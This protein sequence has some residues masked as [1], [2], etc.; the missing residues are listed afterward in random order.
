[1]LPIDVDDFEAVLDDGHILIGGIS[2]KPFEAN[3]VPAGEDHT[4]CLGKGFKEGFIARL[5]L[6]GGES[7]GPCELTSTSANV[8]AAV[9]VVCDEAQAARAKRKGKS[10]DDAPVIGIAAMD[11]CEGANGPYYKIA[12]E[13]VGW[14]VLPE[15]FKV[16]PATHRG[17]NGANKSKPATADMDDEI[18][19]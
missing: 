13:I 8:W 6:R 4:A 2:F 12:F 16:A 7:A 19:F 18:A 3:L 17:G 9:D 1:L 15:E 11:K 10:K 5:W 14:G